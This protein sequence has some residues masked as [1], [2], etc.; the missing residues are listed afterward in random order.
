[1]N[2]QGFKPLFY[3]FYPQYSL[4]RRKNTYLVRLLFFIL[5]FF[6]STPGMNQTS[7]DILSVIFTRSSV[8]HFRD[9]KPEAQQVEVLL[10]AAMAAPSSRNVQPWMFYV[11]EDPDILQ[12]MSEK[13]PSAGMVSQ[14]S[15]A[16]LV[17]GDTTLGNPN[18]EQVL[19]WIM[20]CSAASQ[21][22]L[23]AAHSMGLGAVWTG[24]FPY[25]S[26]IRLLRQLLDIPQHI[27]PLSLIPVGYPAGE[28]LPKDK[29]NP[30][31]VIYK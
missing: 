10:R 5:M 28:N 18:N 6:N 2:K 21:N 15:M 11:I 27:L 14:V 4:I 31:K 23:L 3:Y 25:E 13:L 8:R 26:R 29:W 19:N 22:I 12:E 9:Q 16:I 7:E 30:E 1:M 20:D 24:V 17:C